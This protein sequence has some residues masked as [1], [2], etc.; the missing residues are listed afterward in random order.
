[1]IAST[2]L[3]YDTVSFSEV[4]SRLHRAL[5]SVRMEASFLAKAV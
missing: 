2:L 5:G 3:V 1:M 4:T